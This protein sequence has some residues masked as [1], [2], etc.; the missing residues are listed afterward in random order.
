[1]RKK[2]NQKRGQREK[3]T[4]EIINVIKQKLDEKEIKSR[5]TG[6]AKYFYSIYRKM[7]K[8]KIKKF[9]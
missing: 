4:Q 3:V 7:L 9:T 1:M 6:R 8:K 2:I 5:V